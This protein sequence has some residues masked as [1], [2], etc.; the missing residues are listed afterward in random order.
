MPLDDMRLMSGAA[1]NKQ[2]RDK[3]EILWIF[4]I[5][6]D[7]FHGRSAAAAAAREKRFPV[8]FNFCPPRLSPALLKMELVGCQRPSVIMMAIYL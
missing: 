6:C 5:G 4:S 8:R 7:P 3:N 1:A 2:P